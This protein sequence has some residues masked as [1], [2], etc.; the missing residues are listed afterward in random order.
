MEFSD[1]IGIIGTTFMLTA[2]LLN[3][4]NKLDAKSPFYMILNFVG[5]LCASTAAYIIEYEPFI[6]LEGTWGLISGFALFNHF[7]NKIDAKRNQNT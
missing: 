4:A 1:T 3:L 2:F 5:G 7:K 6:I